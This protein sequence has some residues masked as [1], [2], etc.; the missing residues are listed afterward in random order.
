MVDLCNRSPKLAKLKLYLLN[1]KD[2]LILPSSQ[3]LAS[4]TLPSVPYES[5]Y[6]RDLAEVESD[7]I[8]SFC[9]WLI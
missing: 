4:T 6:S 1:N 2:P 9:S 8:F 5:G 7:N 3:P